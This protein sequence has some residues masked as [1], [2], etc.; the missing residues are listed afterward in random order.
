MYNIL[1][2]EQVQYN[3]VQRKNLCSRPANIARRDDFFFSESRF[4][5]ISVMHITDAYFIQ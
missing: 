1:I 2:D 3:R 5:L 4:E